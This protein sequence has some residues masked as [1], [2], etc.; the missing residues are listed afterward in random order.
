MK[1]LKYKTVFMKQS[2]VG[3]IIGARGTSNKALQGKTGATMNV[4]D[5][6]KDGMTKSWVFTSGKEKCVKQARAEIGKVTE[7][8]INCLSG[9]RYW[10]KPLTSYET[11]K[12]SFN[13]DVYQLMQRKY[14][15]K[16][17]SV[18]KVLV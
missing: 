9:C 8:E 7:G 17:L 3:K 5:Y 6:E 1:N 4:E 14:L 10:C 2:D 12:L 15:K 13:S 16:S 11:R 18:R